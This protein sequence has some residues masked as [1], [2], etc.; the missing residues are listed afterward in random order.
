MALRAFRGEFLVAIDDAEI[1]TVERDASAG[2]VTL[3]QL[4]AYLVE[5]VRVRWLDE[6]YGNPVGVQSIELHYDTLAEL[7]AA[8]VKHLYDQS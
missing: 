2:P 8:E 7:P 4:T 1:E 5:A 6:D 3:D